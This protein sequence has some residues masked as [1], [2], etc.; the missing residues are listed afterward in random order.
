MLNNTQNLYHS[1]KYRDSLQILLK[2]SLGPLYYYKISECT[3]L[4]TYYLKSNEF[5]PN[6]ANF[7]LIL[8][9]CF[10]ESISQFAKFNSTPSTSILIPKLVIQ[11]N[12]N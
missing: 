4:T 6:N 3:Y 2:Q 10:E 1:Y 12:L 5:F 9:C 8:V 7:Q 11:I